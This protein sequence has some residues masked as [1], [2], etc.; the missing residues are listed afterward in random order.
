MSSSSRE[1]TARSAP[2]EADDRALL[3]DCT[4]STSWLRICAA[5]STHTKPQ[6]GAFGTVQDTSREHGKTLGLDSAY[7]AE[8][9]A[10][11]VEQG[12]L[13]LGRDGLFETL[14]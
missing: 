8:T 11:A 2:R 5:T 9:A 6:S 14:E 7:E 3:V 1:L 12:E 13:E 4:H 10:P